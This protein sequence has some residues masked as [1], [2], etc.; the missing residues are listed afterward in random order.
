MNLDYSKEV[1][2]NFFNPKNMGEIKNPSGVG[3][4][5]N[6]RCGDVMK[7][8][9]KVEKKNG[10]E[11]LKDIKFKT[12]GCVAAIASSSAVTQLTKGKELVE[13]E[14]VKMKDVEKTLKGL[15][16]IKLHCAS[17]AIQALNKA[18][19]DYEGKK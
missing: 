4:I 12:F 9:I 16:K 6:P 5:G 3:E 15:P 7:V 19:K 13:V 18:I 2:K 17:M 11:I 8:F 1:M 14:K 10:K